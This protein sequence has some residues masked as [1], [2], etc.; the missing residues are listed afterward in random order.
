MAT[1]KSKSIAWP[2]APKEVALNKDTNLL[3]LI[4]I[5]SMLV[6]HS[7]KM[8]FPQ[9]QVMR[10]IGR[11]AFPLFAYCVSV[12]CVYSRDRMKYLS[13]VV[14]MGLVSQPFYAMALAHTNSSMYAIRF[15]DDP[16]G[17][18]IAVI[19]ALSNIPFIIIQRFNRPTLL[20]LSKRLKQRE[21]RLKNA[22]SAAVR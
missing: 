10:I 15:A 8:F 16:I 12:G 18:V 20:L 3:K 21:E 5:I 22:N 14:L 17:A 19:Y 4:A 11:L 1:R 13:R 6:D 7:G 9:Y 2:F